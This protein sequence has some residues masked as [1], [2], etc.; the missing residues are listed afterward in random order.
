MIA[1]VVA[2]GTS[3]VVL[4]LLARHPAIAP[5]DRP[6]PRSLHEGIVPRAG[7]W[8]IAAGWAAAAVVAGPPPGFGDAAYTALCWALAGLFAVSIAD[9]FHGVSPVVRIV[10]QAGG[11]VAV[12]TTLAGQFGGDAA[13]TAGAALA[14]VAATNFYNFMDGSDGLAGTMAV[15]GFLSLGAGAAVAG[16]PAVALFTPAFATLPFL[17]RN[18][19][20]AR[21]F[22]GDAGSVPLGFL[23]AAASLSGALAGAWP[24][25][26]PPLVFLPFLADAT[27]TLA[28]RALAGERVWEAHRSH[29]YQR[30]V[31]LGAGHRG[32]LAVY[33]ALMVG[34]GATAV[35]CAAWRPGAG[36]PALA[37]W[38]AII[39]LVFAGIDYH[40]R[41]RA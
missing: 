39:A 21:I 23:A 4:A 31:R 7:G 33:G 11:A 14:L 24:A 9:D 1:L 6:N 18:L 40:W 37:F 41:Q 16:L 2:A 25:W 5:R 38:A 29:Y 15:V 3:A 22:L 13:W 34:C 17:G 20:P 30:L 27:V 10:V 35:A 28:K 8:A 26:F 12:A 32:T 36:P 19:P